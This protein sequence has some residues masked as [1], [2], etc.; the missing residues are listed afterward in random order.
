MYWAIRADGM[1]FTAVLCAVARSKRGNKSSSTVFTAVVLITFIV[2]CMNFCL[3]SP[4][5]KR[6]GQTVIVE[7]S[8][9][10][11][12]WWRGAHAAPNGYTIC[13]VFN[14][15]ISNAEFLF[16]DVNYDPNKDF[17]PITNGYYI[18][19]GFLPTSALEVNSLKDLIELSK[20]RPE[21]INVAPPATGITMFIET[22]NQ[23]TGA[24]F[25]V[26]PYK[27]GSEVTNALLTNSVQ[28]AAVGAGNM[29]PYLQSGK[30]KGLSVDSTERFPLLPDVPT[31]KELGH[32]SLR[33]KSWYEFA[34]PAGTRPD[35]I[36]LLHDEIVDIYRDPEF[37]RKFLTNAALE[38]ILDTPE[39]FGRFLEVDRERTG[40]QAKRLGVTPQ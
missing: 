17:S 15:V 20:S 13:N 23:E 8:L 24:K 35:I 3:L 16:K 6:L 25:H 10:R 21:G 19:N 18:I 36:K 9:A 27:S 7:N 5:S 2:V 32:D 1:K 11:V 39:E 22:I 14:D 28:A 4:L 12:G 37:R 26:I 40:V 31:L 30:F 29:I 34:A 38:P 33:I